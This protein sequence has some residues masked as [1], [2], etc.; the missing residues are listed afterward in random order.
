MI[1]K[2]YRIIYRLGLLKPYSRIDRRRYL[3]RLKKGKKSRQDEWAYLEND[4]WQMTFNDVLICSSFRDIR[5]FFYCNPVS[6]VERA[7]IADGLF[8][9]STLELA[10]IFLTPHSIL[11]DIGGNVGTFALP[12]AKAHPEIEVHAYEPNPVAIERFQKNIFINRLENIRLR[13]LA[14]GRQTGEFEFWAF[15]NKDMGLSSFR[16][17]LQKGSRKIN[18]RMVSLDD[19]NLGEKRVCMIKIDTQGYELEVL[20]GARRLI[21]RNYPPILLEHEDDLFFPKS[22]GQKIKMSLRAFFQDLSYEV[23]YVTRK[24]PFMLF[25]VRWDSVL[26]GDLLALPLRIAPHSSK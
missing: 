6:K 24:D 13:E 20:E 7:I 5:L 3:N 12:L 25:P 16:S 19:L 4:L 17:P 26:N 2:I 18:V 15:Q 9:P 11:L 1:R 21:Q 10:D 8:S 22:D 23:F 14:I